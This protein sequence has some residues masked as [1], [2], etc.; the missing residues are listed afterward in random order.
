M[1]DRYNAPYFIAFLMSTFD[2]G[3]YN[4]ENSYCTTVKGSIKVVA[5]VFIKKA[6]RTTIM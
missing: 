1:H 2:F 5:Y 6:T 3:V 4:S